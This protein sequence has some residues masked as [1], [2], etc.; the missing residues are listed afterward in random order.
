M[1]EAGCAGPGWPC[2][3][4][5]ATRA[6]A[7]EVA[8]T[9]PPE[10]LGHYRLG[11]ERVGDADTRRVSGN[12]VKERRRGSGWVNELLRL[13]PINHHRYDVVLGSAFGADAADSFPVSENDQPVC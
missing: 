5:I 7:F 4:P 8:S 10:L 9:T 13:F 12:A 1:R 3:P 11:V 6:E 2:R